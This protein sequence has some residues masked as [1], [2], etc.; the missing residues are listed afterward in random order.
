MKMSWR[1]SSQRCGKNNPLLLLI[2]NTTNY[3]GAELL[4]LFFETAISLPAL[5]LF[6]PA[7]L[8]TS[9]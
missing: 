7:A 2:A 3:I 1:E 6:V 4:V 8:L 9:N 5:F